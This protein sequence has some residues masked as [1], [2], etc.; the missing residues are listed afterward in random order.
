LTQRAC[1]DEIAAM[2]NA[3]QPSASVAA[4][5]LTM[6]R[7]LTAAWLAVIAG[8]LAQMLVVAVRAWAGGAVEAIGFLAEMAQG[9]SWSVLV[10]AAIAVGTLASKSR[11]HIAGLIGLFAGPLAWAAAKGVQKGV[12]ALAGVPQDQLTPLFWS[13]CG[14]KGVEYGLLGFGLAR[15]IS[16]PQA[17]LR[18]Y[19][20]LGLLIGLMS[21]C[22]V[23]ALNLGNAAAAGAAL[24]AP[25]M[26]SLFANELFFATACSIVIFTAQ[27]LT[28]SI[29]VLKS[30]SAA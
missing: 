24:P 27:H 5:S 28:R 13:V 29:G 7:I 12:Q 19:L 10:C 16:G 21:A 15:L 8:V 22:V 1:E 11:E 18:S 20:T 17:P 2:T 26:A 4:A 14:W 6:K 3:A 23:I 30:I 25:R 9:V